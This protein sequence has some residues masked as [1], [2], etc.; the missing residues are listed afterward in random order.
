MANNRNPH[1]KEWVRLYKNG[2]LVK[3]I[4]VKYN[5]HRTTVS[6]VINDWLYTL[7]PDKRAVIQKNH[8]TV[9]VKRKLQRTLDK[10]KEAQETANVPVSNNYSSDLS[11]SPKVWF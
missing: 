7:P 8:Q 2:M 4:A 10:Q 5:R 6:G 11:G 3:E 9:I 1:H